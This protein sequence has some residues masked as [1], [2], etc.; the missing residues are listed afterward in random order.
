VSDLSNI[1]DRSIGAFAVKPRAF[2]PQS[3]FGASPLSAARAE[4]PALR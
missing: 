2:A 4:M 1:H 3:G